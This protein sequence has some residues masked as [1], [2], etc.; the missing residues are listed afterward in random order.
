M[1]VKW[2]EW[3]LPLLVELIV[4]NVLFSCYLKSNFVTSRFDQYPQHDTLVFR[5][6]A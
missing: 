2:E 3:L 1:I 4:Y 5:P 6:F